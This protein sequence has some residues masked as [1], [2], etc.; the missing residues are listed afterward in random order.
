MGE[1]LKP[2]QLKAVQ[3]LFDITISKVFAF[4]RLNRFSMLLGY[5]PLRREAKYCGIAQR[6]L[7]GLRIG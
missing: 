3:L 4:N 7:S 6:R 2:A 1:P 5:L